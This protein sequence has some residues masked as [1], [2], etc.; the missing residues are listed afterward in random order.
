MR[1]G[2]IVGSSQRSGRLTAPAR[3]MPDMLAFPEQ[4]PA[5]ERLAITVCATEKYQYAMTAQA[6]AIHANLR[7]LR[8]PIAII[9]V[10][11]EGLR[12]ID[13]LYRM[14]FKNAGDRVTFIRIAGFKSVEGENYK[15]AAQLLIGQMRTAAFEAARAWGASHCWSLDSDVIPKTSTCFRTLRWILDIPGDYYEVAISPYPSQ[16]GSDFLTGRGTPEHQILPDFSNDERNVSPEL[17][18]R[19]D[20]NKAALAALKPPAQPSKELIEAAQAIDKAIRECPPKGNVFEMNAKFGWKRRG[21]LSQAYPGLG[22]GAIVPSDWCGFGSTLLSRRALDECD[23]SGYEGSGTEDLFIIWNRWHQVGIRIGSALHEPSAHVSRRKD[24]KHFIS[25]VRFVTEGDELA[26]ECAGHIRTIHRPFYAHDKGERH[27]AAN[28]GNPIAPA[29]RV[30]G[31]MAEEPSA[32]GA[33]AAPA[34]E[35]TIAPAGSTTSTGS[36]P[37]LEGLD[38]STQSSKSEPTTLVTRRP[39][40]K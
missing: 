6:R 5:G 16:G 1:C 13:D 37:G 27:D 2:L 23:F 10:G 29:D 40:G 32:G 19:I 26:G 18:K 14:L 12:K 28:D 25:T 17:Q 31:N 11:D 34:A 30:A 9:L 4:D 39:R 8:I 20:E 7:H 3:G 36:G 33:I 38:P 15:S 35:K 21:W 22:R 24:G